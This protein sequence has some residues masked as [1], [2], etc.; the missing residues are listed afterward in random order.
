MTK[1]IIEE[2]RERYSKDPLGYAKANEW[3]D[4]LESAMQE[5]VAEVIESNGTLGASQILR[6]E[7]G[8]SPPVGG[9]LYTFPPD[10]AAEIR[11]LRNR[12]NATK[13]A[14][15]LFQVKMDAKIERLQDALHR[16]SLRSQT[17]MGNKEEY[18][19]IARAALAKEEDQ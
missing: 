5:P 10:A 7:N 3:A 1:K 11:Y 9:K 13:A 4:A 19:R 17:I 12:L 6:W 2:M 8:V 16:I 15:D 18:G 14:N